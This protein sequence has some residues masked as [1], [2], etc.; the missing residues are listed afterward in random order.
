MKKPLLLI[1]AAIILHLNLIY[2]QN[3]VPNPGFE[4]Y[5][6]CPT[7]DG[8]IDLAIGWIDPTG[9]GPDY[10]NSCADISSGYSVPSNNAG[11]MAAHAG[12]AYGGFFTYFS[13]S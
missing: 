4:T 12:N 8:Q 6:A 9:T 10:Y 1:L 5:G 3:L 11:T 13:L 2:A 7:T